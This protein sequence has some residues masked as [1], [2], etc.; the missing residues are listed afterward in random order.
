MYIYVYMFIYSI[1]LSRI[2]QSGMVSRKTKVS[3]SV[4]R[5]GFF[6]QKIIFLLEGGTDEDR[7]GFSVC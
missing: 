6:C 5:V 3:R 1:F 4:R 2:K 7:E